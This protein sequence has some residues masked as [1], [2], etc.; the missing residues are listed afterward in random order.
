MSIQMSYEDFKAIAPEFGEGMI[1]AG[2]V[3]AKAGLD[4]GLLELVKMRVS[5]INGCAFCLQLHLNMAR[6]LK[7]P[8]SKLDLLAVWREVDVFDAREHAALAWAEALTLMGQ[9]P[10]SDEVVH[11]VQ[12]AFSREEV[13]LLSTAAAAINAW[14]RVAGPLQFTPPIR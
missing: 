9:K 6:D 2:A 10:I 4:K 14:N 12:T 11:Q 5:Q 3:A 13:I 1:K 8:A 7:V